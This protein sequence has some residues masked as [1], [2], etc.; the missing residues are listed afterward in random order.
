MNGIDGI[1]A[2]VRF[3]FWCH[4]FCVVVIVL[5]LCCAVRLSDCSFGNEIVCAHP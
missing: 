2:L 4:R 5:C 1:G 3:V